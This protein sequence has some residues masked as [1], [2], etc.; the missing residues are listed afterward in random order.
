MLNQDVLH[1]R[2]ADSIAQIN[3]LV[4]DLLVAPAGILFFEPNDEI[5]YL[6][7]N[8]WST[9]IRSILRSIIFLS[10]EFS[11]PSH[12]GVRREQFCTLL[13]HLST[14]SLGLG[15]YPHSLA[16]AQQNPPVLFFL[17]LQK[18]SHLLS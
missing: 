16:V 6:L 14:K 11:I 13:K 17:M 5:Y 9:S 3:D 2:F 8:L 10:N 1:A 12:N 4:P 15:R 18:D 7:S